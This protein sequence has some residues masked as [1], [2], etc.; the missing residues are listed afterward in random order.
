[1]T[2]RIDCTKIGY[3]ANWVEISEKSG[4]EKATEQFQ[5]H[6]TRSPAEI[7]EM[8]RVQNI[9]P[10]WKDFDQALVQA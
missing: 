7:A 6:D 5:I 4:L 1:M 8:L 3:E 10:V 9:D 2:V